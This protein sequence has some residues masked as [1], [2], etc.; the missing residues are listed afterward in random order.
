MDA[1]EIKE[2]LPQWMKRLEVKGKLTDKIKSL[3]KGN[4]QKIQLIITLIHEPDLIILDE[5]FSGLDPV[6]TE[7]LKQVIFRKRARS[8][9][10]LF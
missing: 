10:Y 7:L 9:H 3:S 2:K 1:K 6:N 8:N 4:Q 5:P